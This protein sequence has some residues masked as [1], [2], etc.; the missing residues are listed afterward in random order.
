MDEG[1]WDL[2]EEGYLTARMHAFHAHD[3]FAVEDGWIWMPDGKLLATVRQT[4]LA[5]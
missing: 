4:R 3:G 1:T 5:G 2:G